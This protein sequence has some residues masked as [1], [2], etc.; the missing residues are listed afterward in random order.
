MENLRN[1]GFPVDGLAFD[2]ELVCDIL[3]IRYW[4]ILFSA[5]RI[6]FYLV[7][8]GHSRPSD[9]Q[10]ERELSQSRSIWIHQTGYAWNKNVVYSESEVLFKLPFIAH[11][12]EHI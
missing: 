2:P 11:K 12:R 10:R 9:R 1:M 5:L 8:V 7:H 6:S 4:Y 3:C